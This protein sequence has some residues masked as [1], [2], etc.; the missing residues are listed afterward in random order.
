GCNAAWVDGHVK[1]MSIRDLA[2][3]DVEYWDRS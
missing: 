3:S 2:R 1:W